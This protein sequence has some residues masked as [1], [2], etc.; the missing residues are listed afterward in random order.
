MPVVSHPLC[1]IIII[2]P[3]P[4]LLITTLCFCTLAALLCDLI[5]KGAV[6]QGGLEHTWGGDHLQQRLALWLGS[7][8]KA[9]LRGEV[10]IGAYGY[11]ACV[12]SGTGITYSSTNDGG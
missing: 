6:T 12:W 2:I 8:R 11:G 3:L 1:I 10:E 5:V 7:G 4:V 9:E